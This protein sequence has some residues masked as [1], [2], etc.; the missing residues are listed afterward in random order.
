MGITDT[1]EVRVRLTAS[2]EGDEV[3]QRMQKSL[4]ALSTAT[5]NA[6]QMMAKTGG[7]GGQDGGAKAESMMKMVKATAIGQFV[8]NKMTDFY[9][10]AINKAHEFYSLIHDEAP[11][12]AAEEAK[13]IKEL[14]GIFTTIDAGGK[15]YDQLLEA[16]SIYHDELEATGIEAGVAGDKMRAAFDQIAQR[17]SK[18][19][20][21]IQKLTEQMAIASK[22]IPGGMES[23]GSGFSMLEMGVVKAKNPLVAL[24]AQTDTLKGNA[25]DVAKQ[26]QKMAPKEM[27]ELAEKAIGKMADKVKDVPLT[28]EQIKQSTADIKS[29][30]VEALGGPI[31]REMMP[32]LER[33][34][35]KLLDN[36]ERITEVATHVGTR[37]GD[38][39]RMTDEV[40]QTFKRV[41]KGEGGGGDIGDKIMAASDYVKEKFQWIVDNTEVMAKTLKDVADK[42][43][44]SFSWVID[45]AIA[46]SSYLRGTTNEDGSGMEKG[47]RKKQAESLAAEINKMMKDPN[48]KDQKQADLLIKRFGMMGGDA[49]QHGEMSNDEVDSY[50]QGFETLKQN[51]MA[52]VAVFDTA[53][54]E[55]DASKMIKAY[56]IAF[57]A[58]DEAKMLYAMKVISGS[59]DLQLALTMSAD[60]VEGGI[61]DFAARAKKAG[62][63][64]GTADEWV[65]AR[66]KILTNPSGPSIQMNGG[67]TFHI[68]Q[69]FRD[70]D[71]DRV[72]VVFREDLMKAAFAR[73]SAKT[74][75]GF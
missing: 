61:L 69:D 67:Q 43:K 14:A 17:S 39:I 53:A 22:V 5:Q 3:I 63:A 64:A 10:T 66:K 27:I 52:S 48:F 44:D 15:S 54:K 32:L 42:V 47:D 21:D 16:A 31:L 20:E 13:A 23:L 34:R 71:P 57:K 51:V 46:A 49:A 1:A 73:T 7:Q 9:N 36:A 37:I 4:E 68:K 45:K 58:H 35:N 24:I 74:P 19:V 18:P 26:M 75:F 40:T 30:F 50:I 28:F 55:A 41:F 33:T 72:A 2:N 65:E 6:N 59:Q 25:K 60:T 8:G 38:I 29:N 56:N 12:A 62:V 11:M 70:Q